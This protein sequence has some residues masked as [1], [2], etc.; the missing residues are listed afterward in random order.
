MTG[1]AQVTGSLNVNG[2][3]TLPGIS[4]V[5]SSIVAAGTSPFTAAGISGSF[6]AT[7]ASFSTR[8]ST[9]ETDITLLRAVTSSYATTGSNDFIG[10]QNIT[11]HITASGNIS[12]YL[13]QTHPCLLYT[14]PSPR[15]RQK[16]RMPSSA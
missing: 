14:S 7:S 3:F 9:N 6:N 2:I 16:S 15:D 8:V 4:N 5:S 12:S 11:G 13:P 10:N 1:S